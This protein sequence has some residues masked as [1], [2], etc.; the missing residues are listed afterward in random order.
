MTNILSE[1]NAAIQTDPSAFVRRCEIEYHDRV[2]AIADEIVNDPKNKILLLAG[3]SGSGKTTSAHILRSYLEERGRQT[4]VIS[5]D[6]FYKSLDAQDRLPGANRDFESVDALDLSL[7]H[8]CFEHIIAAGKSNMPRF[9][10]TTGKSIPGAQSV[11]ITGGGLLIVEGIHALNPRITDKLP[12]E[13]LFRV[14]VSVSTPIVDDDGGVL[15]TGRKIRLIRRVL[16][17]FRFRASSIENTLDLWTGVVKAE[18][19]NLSAFK[20]YADR[21]LITLHPYELAVYR[22]YYP[23]MAKMIPHGTANR[24]YALL[25]ADA[26]KLVNELPDELVPE[27]S[28]IREFIG[29]GKFAQ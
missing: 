21:D 16:R 8:T 20:Q 15:L 10:F 6:D 19:T 25:A 22:K 28:L 13:N 7:I 17:D 26:L 23:L 29:N 1:I 12:S 2:R 5:L 18:E 11:D 24:E 3:P 27:N 4:T 14:Y 9:D